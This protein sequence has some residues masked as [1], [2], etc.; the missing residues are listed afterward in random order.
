[1]ISLAWDS[2]RAVS[3]CPLLNSGGDST[4]F[5]ADE[6]FLKKG[7]HKPRRWGQAE[8]SP[9]SLLVKVLIVIGKCFAPFQAVSQEM[10]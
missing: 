4:P 9:P 1:M 8:P 6:L 3:H 2:Q 10:Q 7:I 5:N